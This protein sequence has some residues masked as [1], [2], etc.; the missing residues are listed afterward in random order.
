MAKRRRQKH[1]KGKAEG[2]VKQQS[3]HVPSDEEVE[4]AIRGSKW[5]STPLTRFLADGHKNTLI[6]YSAQSGHFEML[7]NL[8]ALF[9][10]ANACLA[11]SDSDLSNLVVLSLFGRACGNFFAAVR[12]ATSGQLT[13]SYAQLRVCV[14]N[15]LYAFYIKSHPSLAK[16]WT[17][18]HKDDR[19]R[20][21]CRDSFK[22][23]DMLRSLKSQSFSLG[24]HAKKEYDTCID[25]G[26]HPNERSVVLNLKVAGDGSLKLQLLNVDVGVFEA[27]LLAV[28]RVALC[29]VEIFE[30]VYPDEFKVLNVRERLTSIREQYT[31]IA[32]GVVYDLKSATLRD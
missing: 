21:C 23:G 7:D 8:G 27:S 13:E 11:Y 31:R 19:S 6:A 15:A 24:Q 25:F 32:P 12:L 5:G 16:V 4:A 20:K 1:V 14:E 10:D 29:V 2:H 22:V 26:A 9:E 3:N 18:R 17:D 28:V 30:R